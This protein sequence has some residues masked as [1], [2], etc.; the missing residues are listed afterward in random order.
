MK[1]P[2]P[3]LPIEITISIASATEALEYWL[4]HCVFREHVKLTEIYLTE[5]DHFKV[6]IDRESTQNGS[7]APD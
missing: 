4:N 1:T 3:A 5:R 2:S 6:R 7:H